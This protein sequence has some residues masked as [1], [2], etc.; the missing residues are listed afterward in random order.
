M[1]ELKSPFPY[2]GGKSKVADLVWKKFGNVDNYIEPFAGSL[3]VLMRRP[4][5]HFE[6]Y[7]VETCNDLNHFIVNFW[8]SVSRD[9]A[10]VAEF[11]DCPVTE[12][13]LHARHRWLMR[14]AVS[15]KFRETMATD[16]DAFDAKIAGWW[17]WGQCC[18]I[19]GGWCNSQKDEKKQP[20]ALDH[21]TGVNCGRP[22]LADAYDI[23][24]GVNSNGDLKKKIP[25]LSE[26]CGNGIHQKRP[27]LATGAGDGHP[28]SGKGVHANPQAGTCDARREWLID[29]MKSLAGRLRLV[30]T[31]YGHWARVCDSD[32]TLTRLGLTGVFLDP[33]YPA[34][35]A[36]GAKSRDSSLY[37]TDKSADLNALRDEV[38]AWCRKWAGPRIRVAVCGYE[39]DGYE[40]LGSEGWSVTAWE[41][42]GGYGNQ[43]KGK[44]KSENAKRERI[45]WSPSCLSERSLFDGL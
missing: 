28:A 32:S 3:A 20:P 14:S 2:P 15:T 31:C 25:I 19:G 43:K 40:A 34:K 42:S 45:W 33:P 30:R 16:P 27:M 26:T 39:G 13:D 35:K 24:R 11:A 18:W 12:A 10:R 29:W 8:R 4:E 1:S 5:S 38:L 41:T 44:G 6:N 9:P 17:V 7:R 37:A 36:N 23:G 21:D 22:Q